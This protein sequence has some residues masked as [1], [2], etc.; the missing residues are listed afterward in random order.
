VA[1]VMLVISAFIIFKDFSCPTF[2]FAGGI[3]VVAGVFIC[4]V[5]TIDPD[6]NTTFA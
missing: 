5:K 2:L 3:M 1:P 4:R 6:W